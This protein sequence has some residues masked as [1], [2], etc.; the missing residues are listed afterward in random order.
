MPYSLSTLDTRGWRARW[1]D[2]FVL[3]IHPD[4]FVV[5]Q[6]N[7]STNQSSPKSTHHSNSSSPPEHQR[8][9]CTLSEEPNM[10]YH[11]WWA[12]L[13]QSEKEYIVCAGTHYTW[14]ARAAS[15]ASKPYSWAQNA[16]IALVAEVGK[17]HDSMV[18]MSKLYD[19]SS[20]KTPQSLDEWVVEPL[21]CHSKFGRDYW[22][23]SQFKRFEIKN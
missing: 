18:G 3:G 20:P 21:F 4:K 2:E 23:Y 7:N 17:V 22:S 19:Q 14:T 9:K 13:T 10:E 6:I 12:S 5:D 16:M 8:R 11:L 1:R 15:K